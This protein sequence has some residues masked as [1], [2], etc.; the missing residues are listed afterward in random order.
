VRLAG[1]V[2][3]E[4]MRVVRSYPEMAEG[5]VART[6]LAEEERQHLLAILLSYEE[7]R[8]EQLSLRTKAGL[9]R[10]EAYGFKGGRPRKV[11]EET[12]LLCRRLRDQ[13]WTLRRI[14]D[15]MTEMG[16]PTSQ[17]G[18]HWWPR[19]VSGILAY[20]EPGSA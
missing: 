13:G 17:G 5:F 7:Y 14:G 3:G 2:K 4:R 10:A 19:T 1:I 20:T 12:V 8:H 6:E 15:H 9:R 11:S 18:A 16:I